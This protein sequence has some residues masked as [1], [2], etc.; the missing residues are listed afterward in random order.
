MMSTTEDEPPRADTST[1]AFSSFQSDLD[2]GMTDLS[3][4]GDET[5]SDIP[6]EP[7]FARE[8]SV[9]SGVADLPSVEE[10]RH[11]PAHATSG[12]WTKNKIMLVGGGIIVLLAI[13][14]GVSVGVS[15]RNK[16][17][18]AQPV[19]QSTLSDEQQRVRLASVVTFLIDEDISYEDAVTTPGSPQNRAAAFMAIDDQAQLEVPGSRGEEE[20]FK[21][22]QRYALAVYYYALGGEAWDFKMNFLTPDSTCIWFQTL[23]TTTGQRNNFGAQCDEDGR[24]STILMPWNNMVG[25]L[26]FEMGLLSDLTFLAIPSNRNLSG[27]LPDAMRKLTKLEF[28]HLAGN[29]FAGPVPEWIGELSKLSS[30][31]LSDNAFQGSIPSSMSGMD[32]LRFLAM[33]G[34]SIYGQMDHLESLSN[35]QY[36][37]L[38]HNQIEQMLDSD[39]LR[40]L[41]KLEQ[42]DISDNMLSGRVPR[43][44]LHMKELDVLDLSD[45]LLTGKLPAT[46]PSNSAL[47]FL[48]LHGNQLTGEIPSSIFNLT[49]LNHLDLSQNKF[50]GEIPS[51][52]GNITNLVYLFLSHNDFDKGPLP[53]SFTQLG[54]LRDLSLKQTQ[55]TGT[56][57]TSI[58][59][60]QSLLLLDLDRNELVGS[61]PTELG[62]LTYLGLLLLNHNQ[63]TG[64]IP[65]EVSNMGNL[66]EFWDACHCCDCNLLFYIHSSG[67]ILFVN[68][69]YSHAAVGQ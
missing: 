18:E 50:T 68:F 1:N 67:L 62:L 56:I 33:D 52:L 15:N 46:I 9:R 16:S 66:G 23:R 59:K 40:G 14:I 4:Q 21:F 10:V 20:A 54:T 48:F 55:R 26:P 31:A 47:N 61:L 19:T 34:N 37:Y 25:S 22:I 60:F 53:E 58:G 30:L 57:P 3:I 51:F 65:E 8:P 13:V 35:L 6:A 24:I 32:A 29:A 5:F 45:N 2:T 17:S 11:D 64:T 49:A 39:T 41:T 27:P 43:H 7:S 38:E 12:G 69:I 28:L 63:L 36:L 44:L 42:L